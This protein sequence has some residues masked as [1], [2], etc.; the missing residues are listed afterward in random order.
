MG[1][2]IDLS[3]RVVIRIKWDILPEVFSTKPRTLANVHWA[4]A[5][6]L[7]DLPRF[8]FPIY[9]IVSPVQ[10]T[11]GSPPKGLLMKTLTL[12]LL[13]HS[14]PSRHAPTSTRWPPTCPGAVSVS[15]NTQTVHSLCTRKV[16]VPS[17]DPPITCSH[18]PFQPQ[19][20]M[21]LSSFE[22]PT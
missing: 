1:T 10:K 17:K 11:S 8:I 9:Q 21:M 12:F 16:T 18:S 7:F 2:I 13:G 5:V 19:P 22:H 3:V 6:V 20:Q 4:S 14:L 15:S